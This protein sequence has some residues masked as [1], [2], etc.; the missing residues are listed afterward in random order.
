[1]EFYKIFSYLDNTFNSNKDINSVI[2]KYLGDQSLTVSQQNK[3]DFYYIYVVR[4]CFSEH[5]QNNTISNSHGY[6]CRYCNLYI[7][8]GVRY[9]VR[10]KKHS[11]KVK[12]QNIDDFKIDK[13][14]ILNKVMRRW[15]IFFIYLDIKPFWE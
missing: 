9:H 8:K 4:I 5:W 3:K 12:R 11:K 6:Y 13:K 1:M 14:Y 15:T 2:N 7:S 10:T